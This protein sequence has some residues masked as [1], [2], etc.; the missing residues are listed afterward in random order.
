MAQR[1]YPSRESTTGSAPIGIKI[2]CGLSVAIGLFAIFGLVLSA[3][4]Y[5]A[6]MAGLL[7]V[8]FGVALLLLMGVV[9]YGLW[10][11]KTWAWVLVVVTYTA[12]TLFRMIPPWSVPELVSILL[13]TLL[14]AYL[15]HVRGY[16]LGS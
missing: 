15:F 14:L 4:Q 3:G 5:S 8:V 7:V 16:Y 1:S 11:L 9:V 10:T 6:G 13:T 2:L 12:G